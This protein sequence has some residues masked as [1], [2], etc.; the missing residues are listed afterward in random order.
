MSA[1]LLQ[2]LQDQALHRRPLSWKAPMVL[3][4]DCQPLHP[5]DKFS[6]ELTDVRLLPDLYTPFPSH[7]AT[8]GPSS[9]SFWVWWLSGDGYGW[10]GQSVAGWSHCPQTRSLVSRPLWEI[11]NVVLEVGKRYLSWSCMH[12]TDCWASWKQGRWSPL[13]FTSEWTLGW[14]YRFFYLSMWNAWP[15][16]CWQSYSFPAVIVL[17]KGYMA[18]MNTGRKEHPFTIICLHLGRWD[19]GSPACGLAFVSAG[20]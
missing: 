14:Y 17:A 20:P 2:S 4:E 7:M 16:C 8:P 11:N 15:H 5:R 3:W 9:P 13:T 19:L 1:F 18:E 10:E 12:M 6:V